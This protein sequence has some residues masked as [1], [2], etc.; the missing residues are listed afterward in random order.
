MDVLYSCQNLDTSRASE[1][2][3]PSD[4]VIISDR[5]LATTP[6]ASSSSLKAEASDDRDRDESPVSVLSHPPPSTIRGEE[7]TAESISSSDSPVR[8]PSASYEDILAKAS[9]SAFGGVSLSSSSRNISSD[10]IKASF[11]ARSESNYVTPDKKTELWASPSSDAS[12]Q[13]VSESSAV[14][15]RKEES[16]RLTRQTKVVM[17]DRDAEVEITLAYTPRP[18]PLKSSSQQQPHLVPPSTPVRSQTLQTSQG[19]LQ[20]SSLLDTEGTPSPAPR[21][22]L[23]PRRSP[24]SRKVKA[25]SSLF[26]FGFCCTGTGVGCVSPEDEGE[27][28]V[29]EQDPQ[30]NVERTIEAFLSDPVGVNGG[31][32][33]G[34]QAWSSFAIVSAPNKSSSSTGL[35]DDVKA[36]LRKRACNMN[37]R[38]LRVRRIKNDIDPFQMTPSREI[39]VSKTSSFSTSRKPRRRIGSTSTE[40]S[41]MW[42]TMTCTEPTNESPFVLRSRGLGHDDE[43]LCYDS[44]PEDT[45]RRRSRSRLR[46]NSLDNKLSPTLERDRGTGV[47]YSPSK[48]SIH[49]SRALTNEFGDDAIKAEVQVRWRER[50]ITSLKSTENLQLSTSCFC[51]GFPERDVH[52]CLAPFSARFFY[53]G[54]TSGNEGMVGAWPTA[55]QVACSS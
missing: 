4:A 5:R 49:R 7:I 38:R 54:Q 31:W 33:N 37:S 51:A 8:R 15:P 40:V 41:S 39:N 22:N 16:S 52:S 1:S 30:K 26:S 24:P 53:Q 43:Q 36:V 28:T 21:A 25:T 23:F 14:S 17:G 18:S 19:I 48:H 3:V 35:K 55:R 10:K 50:R 13:S 44:D 6:D 47:P 46:S 9:K 45:T 11:R 27:S 42:E 34:W 29:Q 20:T 32:C 12:F 2:D